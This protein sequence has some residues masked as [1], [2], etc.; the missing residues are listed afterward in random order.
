MNTA[1]KFPTRYEA[2]EKGAAD[3]PAPQANIP[4]DGTGTP[5]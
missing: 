2:R 4:D 3:N 1:D 5:L